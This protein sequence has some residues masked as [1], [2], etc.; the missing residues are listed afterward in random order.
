MSTPKAFPKIQN[1]VKI[2][3]FELG[4]PW[5]KMYCDEYLKIMTNFVT[6]ILVEPKYHKFQKRQSPA[7][8]ITASRYVT[9][10]SRQGR[11]LRIF[12]LLHPARLVLSMRELKQL[13]LMRR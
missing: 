3:S 13:W 2:V 1:L 11:A 7:N 9:I 12:L 6:K 5:P 8:I 4:G 10:G